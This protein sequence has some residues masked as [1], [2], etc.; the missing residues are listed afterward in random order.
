MQNMKWFNR[1]NKEDQNTSE[2]YANPGSEG[3]TS[4][5]WKRAAPRLAAVIIVLLI[6]ILGVLNLT[7]VFNTS[8]PTAKTNTPPKP[9]VAEKSTGQKK[10]TGSGSMNSGSTNTA[11]PSSSPAQTSQNAQ[12]REPGASNQLANAGPG[13][14]ASVFFIATIGGVL[15]YQVALRRRIASY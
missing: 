4:I 6:L 14:A 3:S 12:S 2:Y 7:G 5:D 11:T 8:E 15:T 1:Q 9:Q 13:E 10:T